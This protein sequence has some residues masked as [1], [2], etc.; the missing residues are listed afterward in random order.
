MLWIGADEMDYT[1][2]VDLGT[3][4]VRVLAVSS[5]GEVLGSGVQSLTSQKNGVRHE[6]HPEEWWQS[7]SNACQQA[8]KGLPLE[9]LQAIAVDG[10]SGTILLVDQAGQP[11]TPGLMYDDGRAIEEAQ[12]INEVGAAVW[13]NL[14]YSRM[15]PSWALPKLL[16]LLHQQGSFPPETRLAHQTDFINRRLVGHEVPSDT[17][18]A[19]KTGYDLLNLGWPHHIFESLAIPASLL[20]SVILPGQ[21]IG[22]LCSQAANQT[23]L[24]AGLPVMAGMTDGCA[25]QIGSGVTQVGD[26]NS[27]LGTTL[28]LKGVTGDLIHDPL[29]VV[30]SHRSPDNMW[31]PGG[32]SSC[33]AGILTARFPGYSLATLDKQAQQRGIVDIVAYPLSTPGERFPFVAPHAE[34]FILGKPLDDIDIYAALLQGVAFVERLCFDYLALLGAPVNGE[35]R[36]TGGG[37]RSP[38]WNQLRANVLDR[39]VSIPASPE[40]ALGMAILAASHGRQ[41]A[42]TAENMV[43]IRE[44]ILPEGEQIRRLTQLYIRFVDTLEQRGWL[45]A[46]V[47]EYARKR[48]GL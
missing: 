11:L 30:Y 21:Q 37:S 27:V 22:T 48:T 26:W 41:L 8:V 15:Q 46:H 32:A 34:S 2:G 10:T 1:L 14:G 45:A 23:G 44:H 3:Q 33:G 4:S 19:L 13:Q 12:R 47:A 25:A 5:S 16:W 6:Q 24:P 18:S 28:V 9:A 29:G 36:F 17:S 39:P 7:V 40:P 43:R 31:L 20:P 42:S 38:Y 35:L